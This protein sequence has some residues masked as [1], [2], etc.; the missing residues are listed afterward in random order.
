MKIFLKSQEEIKRIYESTNPRLKSLNGLEVEE[1]FP[2]GPF[3]VIKVIDLKTEAGSNYFGEIHKQNFSIGFII[4]I[5]KAPK[6]Y[7]YRTNSWPVVKEC[8]VS[9]LEYN[10]NKVLE[11]DS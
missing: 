10:L 7:R 5:S 8:T 4:D 11:N 1:N 9:M 6:G 2:R 3:E